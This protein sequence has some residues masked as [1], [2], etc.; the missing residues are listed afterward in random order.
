MIALAHVLL[1]CAV[2]AGTIIF[3]ETFLVLGRLSTRRSTETR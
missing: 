3:A 1:A 2:L